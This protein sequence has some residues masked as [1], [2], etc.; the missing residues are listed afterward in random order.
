MAIEQPAS[1]PMSILKTVS[2]QM[3]SFD[4]MLDQENRPPNPA[5]N[6]QTFDWKGQ[7]DLSS[8]QVRFLLKKYYKGC[9]LCRTCMNW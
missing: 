1:T 4:K 9:I 8:S 3:V 6:T 2:T 5:D 7:K